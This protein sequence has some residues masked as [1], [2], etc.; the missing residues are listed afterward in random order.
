MDAFIIMIRNVLLF[1][2]LAVPGYLLAKRGMIKQEQSGV[3]SKIL[4]Y[5]GM[6]FLIISSV[7]KDELTINRDTIFLMLL[8]AVVGIVYTIAMFLVSKPL[9]HFEKDK[10]TNGMLRFCAVFSNNGFL[11]LPLAMAVFS[12]K[13]NLIIVLIILNIVTNVLMFTLGA[14][15]ISGDKQTINVKKAIL[16]PVLI[17][18]FAGIIIKLLKINCGVPEEVIKYSNHFNNIVTPLSMTILGIKLAD[19]KITS[20]FTSAKCYYVSL[21][22]LVVFPSVIVAVLFVL[23]PI[24]GGIIDENVILGFFV[25]IAMPTA[26]LASTFADNYSGDTKNAVVFTLGTTLLS[27]GTIPVLYWILNSII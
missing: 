5:V 25:A 12:D 21:L 3:L 9:A 11:G 1:A 17:G 16:N 14:Y 8:A 23:R 20:L 15:L 27:I 4:M 2:V 18:L 19:V 24:S 13:P 6:P 7:L 10:K 22:K 26:G